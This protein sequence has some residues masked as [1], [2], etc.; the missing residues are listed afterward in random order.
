MNLVYTFSSGKI[1]DI[2][3]KISV[4][5][6]EEYAKKCNADFL[7]DQID[8]FKYPLFGKFN[9]GGLL[10]KYDRVLYLD[11]DI[12]IRP[13]APNIFAI[14][15]ENCFAAF[16]EGSWCNPGE[17]EARFDIAV[18]AADKFNC[19]PDVF[20]VSRHYYNGAVFIANKSHQKLFDLGVLESNDPMLTAITIEQTIIS[21]RIQQAGFKTY[22]LPI[23]FNAMSWRWPVQYLYENYFIH[24]AGF[25]V[26]QRYE[27]MKEDS[28]LLAER[29]HEYYTPDSI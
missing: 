24:Y 25:D 28:A 13:D 14:A 1:H 29:Y 26:E 5:L 17:L 8:D 4:P 12:L 16:N 20:D 3:A 21:L 19:R 11:C 27:R 22:D 9:V 10:S 6:M 18:Q 7:Y 23:C 2:Y 15:P